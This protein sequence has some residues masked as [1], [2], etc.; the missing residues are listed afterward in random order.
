MKKAATEMEERLQRIYPGVGLPAISTIH[1]LCYSEILKLGG[2]VRLE[3]LTAWWGSAEAR[4]L[5]SDAA[6]DTFASA[7][8]QAGGVSE[9]AAVRDILFELGRD[10]ESLESIRVNAEAARLI[11]HAERTGVA[12]QMHGLKRLA[13]SPVELLDR[14][15]RALIGPMPNRSSRTSTSRR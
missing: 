5:R 1:S 10:L 8:R 11:A 4:D 12:P 6:R 9:N 3:S 15:A 13:L 7:Y 14:A 2:S